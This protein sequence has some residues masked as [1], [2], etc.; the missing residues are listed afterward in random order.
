[1]TT[2]DKKE[3]L[4]LATG[5]SDFAKKH[6]WISRYDTESDAF[7][8]TVPKLSESAR[9]KYFDDEVAFYITNDNK[10]EGVFLEYFKSNFIKHHTNSKK[11]GKVLEQLEKK[12]KVG[13][14]L[15]KVDMHQVDKIAPDLEE[16]IKIS[17]ANRL[18][19]SPC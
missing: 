4:D 14:D 5:F 15:V 1:M 11:I 8:I 10:V 18:D 13:D 2:Q 12:Q 6:G 3:L 16:A 17:L 19:L 7:S 9:V